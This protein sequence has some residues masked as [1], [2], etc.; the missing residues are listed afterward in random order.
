MLVAAVA[1]SS[2][3][4]THQAP[5]P[6]TCTCGPGPCG[7]TLYA[8]SDGNYFECHEKYCFAG[9]WLNGDTCPP[10][11]EKGGLLSPPCPTAC[12]V[13]LPTTEGACYGS[14][15]SPVTCCDPDCASS[16]VTDAAP[17]LD[18][19]DDAADDA[20]DAETPDATDGGESGDATMD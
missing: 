7:F 1:C 3:Q 14:F 15:W 17:G 4:P 18:S 8:P 9:Q 16:N 5:P 2:S 6:E 12:V 19:G 10:G 13:T 20:A 11:W